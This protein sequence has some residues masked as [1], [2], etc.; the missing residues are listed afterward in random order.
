MAVDKSYTWKSN[1]NY[2]LNPEE[3]KIGRGEQGVLICQP[4]KS[5]ILPFWRFKTPEV[6]E[7]SSKTIYKMFLNYLSQKDFVG[8]DMARK[9]LQMG[10]TRSRRYANFK[11]GKKFSKGGITLPKGTG[12]P[13]KIRSAD[14]FLKKYKKAINNRSY[15]LMKEKWKILEKESPS[16]KTK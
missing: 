13:L 11:S 10:F 2:K 16:V 4:Y 8:A 12:D 1:I 6:A 15:L 5:E 9:Y 7:E 14:I 3:Y